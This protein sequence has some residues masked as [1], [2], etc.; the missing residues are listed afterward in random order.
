M[1]RLCGRFVRNMTLL[2]ST[3]R[4]GRSILSSTQLLISVR[5]TSSSS[6]TSTAG[7]GGPSE[8]GDQQEQR[9]IPLYNFKTYT[10]SERKKMTTRWENAFYGKLSYE[11]GM[12]ERYANAVDDEE[13]MDKE[14]Q[15]E[16]LRR[17][18]EHQE[19]LSRNKPKRHTGEDAAT[20]HNIG[21]SATTSSN[22]AT[23]RTPD[24]EEATVPG[25]SGRH[26]TATIPLDAED[27]SEDDLRD[28]HFSEEEIKKYIIRTLTVAERRILYAQDYGSS[29]MMGYFTSG[30]MKLT[31][32]EGHLRAFGM[33]NEA[34]EVKIRDLRE[35]L[36]ERM[37]QV[38]L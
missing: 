7:V 25:A 35:E 28:G 11:P 32:A 36:R 8:E 18:V 23:T 2:S 29:R 12:R 33:M 37:S 24:G 5:S 10:G 26:V 31:E 3:E 17:G 16:T 14:I 21:G 30:A 15:E 1:N 38:D 13:R 22:S 27:L 9:H 20:D 34:L 19:S 4:D 6:K